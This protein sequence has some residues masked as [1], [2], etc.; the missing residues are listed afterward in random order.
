MDK[1]SFKNHEQRLQID[2]YSDEST[3]HL[4]D[5]DESLARLIGKDAKASLKNSVLLQQLK[6]IDIL[7]EEEQ[8][9]LIKVIS[10]YIRDFRAKQAYA[11]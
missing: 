7:P 2:L 11:S 8:S 9:I 1:C 3:A 5:I 6:E 10:V 4:P